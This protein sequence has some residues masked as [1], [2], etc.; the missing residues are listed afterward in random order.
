MADTQID[1]LTLEFNVN[2]GNSGQALKSISKELSDFSKDASKIDSVVSK[3]NQLSAA[4]T[5]LESVKVV[6]QSLGRLTEAL[7]KLPDSFSGISPQTSQGLATA[8]GHITR[9][10]DSL[11]PES[12]ERLQ[13]VGQAVNRVSNALGGFHDAVS[14]VSSDDADALYVNLDDIIKATEGIDASRLSAFD[15]LGKSLNTFGNVMKGISTATNGVELATIS[16]LTTAVGGIVNAAQQLSSMPEETKGLASFVNSLKSIPNATASLTSDVIAK[17]TE[18]TGQI[19][20][21]MSGVSGMGNGEGL[22]SLVD[23]LGRLPKLAEK[24]STMGMASFAKQVKELTEALGP[25]SRILPGLYAS[26]EG[27]APALRNIASSNAQIQRQVTDLN[28]GLKSSNSFLGRMAKNVLSFQMLRRAMGSVLTSY[29]DFVEDVNLASV[30]LGAFGNQANELATKMQDLLG[31]DA[32]QALRTMGLIQNLTTSFGV[33][34]KSAYQMS[35]NLTQLGYDMASF[36]NVSTENAFDT[37]ESALTGSTK[38]IR[39]YGI[40]ISNARLKQEAMI[41]AQEKGIAGLSS[42]IDALTQADKAVLRYIAIMHQATNAQGD[43]ARTLNSPAN[44]FRVLSA[45][46]ELLSRSLGAVLIPVINELLPRIIAMVQALRMAISALAELLGIPITFADLADTTGK[47]ADNAVEFGEGMAGAAKAAKS[48]TTGIDE[49]NVLSDNS[50]GGGGGSAGNLLSDLDLSAYGYDMFKGLVESRVQEFL[51]KM[52]SILKKIGPL[53][54]GI[55]T[56]FG[57]WKISKSLFD[58]FNNIGNLKGALKGLRGLPAIL[59][60]VAGAVLLLHGAF[61]ALTGNANIVN[62]LEMIGGAFLLIS[63]LSAKF[64]IIGKSIGGLAAGAITLGTALYDI[65]RNGLNFVNGLMALAG[66]TEIIIGLTNTI[67]VLGKSIFYAAEQGSALQNFG[68]LL[69]KNAGPI[70]LVVTAVTAAAAAF[71]YFREKAEESG[72]AIYEQT[73]AYKLLQT[74]HNDAAAIMERSAKAIESMTEKYEH[75]QKLMNSENEYFGIRNLVDDIFAL[76]DKAEKTDLE[77][78]EMQTKVDYLNSLGLDGLQIEWDETHEAIISDKEAIY[79]VINALEQQAR[80]AALQDVLTEAYK[81]QYQAELDI[82]TANRDIGASQSMMEG[83]QNALDNYYNRLGVFGRGL[84]ELGLDAEYN[85]LKTVLDEA[86]T[87]YGESNAAME[88]AIGVYDKAS[89]S[90]QYASQQIGILNGTIDE[91]TAADMQLAEKYSPR[92]ESIVTNWQAAQEQVA[93]GMEATNG[94]VSSALDETDKLIEAEIGVWTTSGV[95]MPQ[96]LA[97]GI[98]ENSDLVTDSVKKMA[99]EIDDLVGFSVPE[100]GPLSKADTYMPDMLKLF[101]DGVT[102]HAPELVTAVEQMCSSVEET[103]YVII[104][105]SFVWGQDLID[106][107]IDGIDSKMGELEDKIKEL[108]EMVDS[109]L[110]FSLP[111]KGPLSHADEWMPDMIDLMSKGIRDSSYRVI[112]ATSSMASQLSAPLTGAVAGGATYTGGVATSVVSGASSRRDDN[113]AEMVGLMRQMILLMQDD[114]Q[115]PN[116]NLNVTLDGKQ[117]RSSIKK[118]ERDQGRK[119]FTSGIIYG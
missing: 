112:D 107:F 5:G 16:H 54:A 8:L 44:Q 45:Q 14:S 92:I 101:T 69:V 30:S 53:V 71:V 77:F 97:K 68:Y 11:K 51:E 19:P 103:V 10:T 67:V 57:L 32:S 55:A 79:D 24:L 4:F 49:L 65:N 83:A 42:N 36:F 72:R 109:Y 113:G 62:T 108:A 86:T 100:K 89:E 119:L 35:S 87:A 81:Q 115:E 3:L 90:A 22:K 17:L 116:F 66:V 34:S 110:G 85:A 12:V 31:V 73:D 102:E 25:L 41:L 96:E 56:A 20:Q 114:N 63:G 105:A 23:Q 95:H 106:N 27:F 80:M 15:A 78:L 48:L 38:A 70:A 7:S 6:G 60:T 13:V 74:V 94:V 28:T 117:I 76:N 47:A 46:V 64:G 43:M 91:A 1:S 26:A 84:A 93:A 21:I 111:D 82:L 59:E 37:I 9:A 2:T 98:E 52:Q 29:N 99:Q 104:D 50:G 18:V 75:L 118:A 88:A 33:A 61:D 58:W 39:A 40:D